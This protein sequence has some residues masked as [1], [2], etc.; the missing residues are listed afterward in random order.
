MSRYII[1]GAGAVGAGLAAQLHQ[2]RVPYVLVGRGDNITHIA[3][4]GLR[5]TRPSGTETVALDVAQ[6]PDEVSLTNSD[7][8]VVA[9]KTQD[10]DDALKQ[11]AWR[12]VEIDGQASVA[13][14]LPLVTLQNGL[15]AERSALRRFDEVYGG[16][17]LVPARYTAIGEVVSG[18]APTVGVITIGRVPSG[19]SERIEGIATDLRRAGYAVQVSDDVAAWK[20]SK[21]LWSVRN[22]L[23]VLTGEPDQVAGLSQRLADE[24]AAVLEAAGL[25]VADQTAERT[26]DLSGFK[27]DPASGIQAGQ[28]STWQSFARSAGSTEVDFLNGEIVLLGALHGVPTPVNRALQVLLGAA[29]AAGDPPGFHSIDELQIATEYV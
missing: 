7:V 17:L 6:S 28:Q 1:I 16:S 8:L 22:G 15:D 12:P 3:E 11:W 4:H 27:V 2:A 26:I 24:A 18:A 19:T 5:Y 20:A 23:E 13:A 25:R 21:L 29:W 14:A 9:T 10:F